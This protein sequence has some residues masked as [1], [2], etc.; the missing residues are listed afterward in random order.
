MEKNNR[1][2]RTL[3]TVERA[4]EVIRVL[5][6]LDGAG[7]SA[8]AERLDMSVSSAHSQLATLHETGYLVKQNGEYSLSYK[9]L[10]MGESVRNS[11]VLFQFGRSEADR[12][13]DETGQYVHLFTEE[14]GL[15]VNIYESRGEHAREYEYQSMKLQHREPLHI[16]ASGKAILASLDRTDVR[17]ILDEHGLEQYTENTI[18]DEA[19]LFKELEQIRERGYAVNNEEEVLGFKAVAAPIQANSVSVIGSIS[20]A[21]PA[22]L[23]DEHEFTEE[24]STK[25]VNAANMI[26]VNINMSD[27]D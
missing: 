24:V 21:G 17:D 20:A 12:L 27:T 15:G 10:L 13:A 18:T 8:V 4:T 11:S 14:R 5:S 7:V 19:T 25:V 9:F 22:R 16:T 1:S 3:Q 6:D 2:W 26:Q 23:F